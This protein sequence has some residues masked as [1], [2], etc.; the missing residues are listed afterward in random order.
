M[1]RSVSHDCLQL[2]LGDLR[3]E[4]AH[5]L[6]PLLVPGRTES[7][8]FRFGKEALTDSLARAQI[9]GG[10]R[11]QFF[12]A[13]SNS[14]NQANKG[15]ITAFLGI[16]NLACAPIIGIQVLIHVVKGYEKIVEVAIL[17]TISIFKLGEYFFLTEE[18]AETRI[19]GPGRQKGGI[20]GQ[21]NARG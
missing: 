1:P 15:F 9:L 21:M 17:S 18:S 13:A 20:C 7:T 8:S 6:S 16:R 11:V 14:G 5:E 3:R 19:D 4:I 2:Y 12:P 10:A